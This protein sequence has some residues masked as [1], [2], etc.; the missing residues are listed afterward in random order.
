MNQ[1]VADHQV[2]IDQLALVNTLAAECRSLLGVRVKHSDTAMGMFA[3]M[4]AFQRLAMGRRR[5][6]DQG[7]GHTDWPKTLAAHGHE[8]F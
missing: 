7:Y 2:A 1:Q 8:G 6:D 4:W 3:K 5:H